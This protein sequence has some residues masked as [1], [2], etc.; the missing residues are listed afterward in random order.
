ML[1]KR[2][3]GKVIAKLGPSTISFRATIEILKINPFVRVSARRVRAIKAN[4]KRPLPVLVRVLAHQPDADWRRRL[5][6]LPAR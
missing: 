1:A 2:M 3:P 6:S 4:W 5:L